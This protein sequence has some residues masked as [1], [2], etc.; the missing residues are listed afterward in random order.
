MPTFLFVFQLELCEKVY[1]VGTLACTQCDSKE[2]GST[3][4][5][6]NVGN[7]PGT[8]LYWWLCILKHLEERYPIVCVCPILHCTR[9]QIAG[10]CLRGS[11]GT[12]ARGITVSTKKKMLQWPGPSHL[13]AGA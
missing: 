10:H 12:T 7:A 1:M 13:R 5:L 2:D 6:V 3:P 11:V 9:W 4:V 8:Q